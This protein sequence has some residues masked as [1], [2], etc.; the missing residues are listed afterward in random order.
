MENIVTTRK[1]N[2]IYG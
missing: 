2:G 1:E